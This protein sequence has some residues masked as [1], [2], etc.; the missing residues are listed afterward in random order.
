MTAT[1]VKSPDRSPEGLVLSGI[2]WPTYQTLVHDLEHQPSLRLTYDCGQ[3]EIRMPSDLHESYKKLLGR[4][5][6]ALTEELDLEIRSLGS[7][8]CDR[9][10]HNRGLEPDQCY[11]IQNE[12]AVYTNH[13][14]R[15]VRSPVPSRRSTKIR[16]LAL[17]VDVA[18]DA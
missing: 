9:K 11:Y 18:A 2:S 12:S 4:F 6:E 14:G 3:L 5:V 1:L 17:P 10:D 8:T 16:L 15:C 13:R 7:R